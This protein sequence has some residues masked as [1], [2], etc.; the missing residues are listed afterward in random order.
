MFGDMHAAMTRLA[1]TPGPLT[2]GRDRIDIV[3]NDGRLIAFDLEPGN[4]TAKDLADEIAT[5]G[6]MTCP[7]WAG[8]SLVI[9]QQ[10][11]ATIHYRTT[12]DQE[13]S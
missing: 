9:Y 1:N 6:R 11:I 5:N 2:P 12:P 10:A 7:N 8:G 13:Q 3:L 4:A